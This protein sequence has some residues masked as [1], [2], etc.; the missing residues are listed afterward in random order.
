MLE[1]LTILAK[2][3]S[4]DS[5]AVKVLPVVVERAAEGQGISSEALVDLLLN[6]YA[7]AMYIAS[8]ARKVSK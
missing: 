1:K 3:T 7:A 2:K 5:D 4:L 6:N 8:V